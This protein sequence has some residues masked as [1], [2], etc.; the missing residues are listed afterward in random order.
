[1]SLRSSWRSLCVIG[2]AVA[3][4][5]LWPLS[6]YRA[7]PVL[8]PAA[9]IAV[10]LAA[11]IVAKPQYGVA[12]AVATAPIADIHIH[13]QHPF[14]ILLLALVA[15][16]VG[17]GVLLGRLRATMLPAVGA[18]SLAFLAV[19]IAADLHGLDPHLALPQLR[20]LA[21][22]VGLL[23]AT[24]MFC[25]TRASMTMV[26]GG[27]ILGLAVAG[28][29]GVF[30]Q[31][32]GHFSDIEIVVQGQTVQRIEGSFGHP[33]SFAGYLAVYIPLAAAITVSRSFPA[34]LRVL[35]AVALILA[36]VSLNY[37]Y[38]RGAVFALGAGALIWL[39]IVRPRLAVA[40][41]LT[42]GIAAATLLPGTLSQRF[43]STSGADVGLRMD[44][45]G[46]A[47]DI[48][49]EHPVLG[50]GGGNFP[51]A[52]A[53]LPST[54]LFATQKRL[55]HGAQEIVPPHA[56]SLYLNFFAEDGTIGF[57]AFV[58][59]AIAAI[60]VAFRCSKVSDPRGR[61]IGVGLGVGLMVL[62][63]HSTVDVTSFDGDRLEMPLFA[64][65]A[66]AAM[67]VRADRRSAEPA[68]ALD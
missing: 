50:V 10:G 35:S 30:Q 68:A 42:V 5:A 21:A 33:N 64:L 27:I 8:L 3:L 1:M 54:L 18:A 11:L 38:T 58:L 55:L 37:T 16:L 19:V 49:S 12:V 43:Q 65:L 4:A 34:R 20:W 66:V 26:A 51:V 9:L 61:V 56:Q 32:T 60:G 23:L 52:Y 63:V 13:G 41:A 44:I 17:Y 57:V 7:S 48:Y 25:R 46:A 45:W 47:L 14:T 15:G 24:L 40:V 31:I 53:A 22:A 6:A 28:A 67:L 36:L 59:L 62:A 29:Q 2:V 39:A